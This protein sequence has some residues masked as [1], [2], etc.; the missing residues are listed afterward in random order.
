MRRERQWRPRRVRWYHGLFRMMDSLLSIVV[1]L[2]AAAVLVMALSPWEG[3]TRPA[4]VGQDALRIYTRQPE[5]APS[6]NQPEPAPP[7]D[8]PEPVP[9]TD[10]PEPAP[11]AD[12]PEPVPPANQPEPIPTELAPAEPID[13]D[14]WELLLV[15]RWN[16]LPEGYSIQTVELRN[17]L[18]VDERCYQDLQ[19]M[20][21][22]C[23]AEG[24]S[25]VICSAY[26]TQEYQERLYRA[27]TERWLERG[28]SQ[29]DA[30]EEAGK[31]VAVPGTSEH[32]LGLA[33]DIVDMNNQR[34]DESQ[35]RT[36]VQIWLMAHSWEYGF[37]L[38][39]PS[40]KSEITGIIYEPWH[41][42]YVG[43]EH[44]E[45]IDT[46]NVCLEEYL[47]GAF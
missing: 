24:L 32:Q 8:Q 34:L 46:L 2:G 41:Y 29:S 37:I 10:R 35:E 40:G 13:K 45:R 31:S 43:R 30:E 7:T 16:P 21:D 36:D 3:D 11:S 5:P 19:A 17:G 33:V 42:R 1:L 38:R 28:Y 27:E 6:A 26:R 4:P 18:R 39:Y 25:P 23:R 44:A 22:A 20:M 47:S 14:S 15:N 12:Q 9:P